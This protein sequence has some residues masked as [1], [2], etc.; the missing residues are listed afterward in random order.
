MYSK[1]I[2]S[3]IGIILATIAIAVGVASA[4]PVVPQRPPR[5]YCYNEPIKHHGRYVPRITCV[6]P[7]YPGTGR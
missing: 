4:C 1:K 2:V 7:G 5:A 6:S 3:F